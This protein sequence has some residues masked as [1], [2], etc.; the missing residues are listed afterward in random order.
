MRNYI[1]TIQNNIFIKLLI[2]FIV[3]DVIFGVLRA[4]KEHKTNSAVG[5][6][7]LI[8]KFG[9]IIAGI[10]FLVVD[11]LMSINFIGFIPKSVLE[12][13]PLKEIGLSSLFN[14]LF[15]LFEALSV[16]KN[17][18]RCGMPIPKKL[19]VVLKR[20]L[21]DFTSEIEEGDTK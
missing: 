15:I 16:L 9:M 19:E 1:E 4:L 17:M 8:R 10:G 13:M 20:L 2:I 7:G 18:Y 5:I 3:L 11:R 14:L 6:N 21:K 12:Y